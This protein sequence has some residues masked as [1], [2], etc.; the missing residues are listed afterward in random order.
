[1]K[2]NLTGKIT[3]KCNYIVFATRYY[4]IGKTDIMS[5]GTGIPPTWDTVLIQQ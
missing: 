4:L 5:L 2:N 1:M 3:L